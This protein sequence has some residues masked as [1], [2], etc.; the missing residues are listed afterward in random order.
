MFLD[1]Y[2]FHPISLFYLLWAYDEKD[3]KYI[4]IFAIFAVMY[5]PIIKI[6]LIIK[7]KW[8]IVN[9]A[10]ALCF[11][12]FLKKRAKKKNDFLTMLNELEGVD[13]T[14]V[15]RIAKCIYLGH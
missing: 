12:L 11:F 10:T 7:S 13:G 1:H 4:T 8:V 9:L 2:F 5:N 3:Q 6:Y 15:L 14:D